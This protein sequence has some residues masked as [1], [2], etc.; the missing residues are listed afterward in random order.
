M[1]SRSISN[2]AIIKENPFWEQEDVRACLMFA[3]QK[4]STDIEMIA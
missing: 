2:E 4:I 3:A 1:L